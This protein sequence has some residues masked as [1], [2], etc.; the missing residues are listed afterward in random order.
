MI[1][2]LQIPDPPPWSAQ[3]AAKRQVPCPRNRPTEANQG[4]KNG[5][6]RTM[7]LHF[8][9][10]IPTTLLPVFFVVLDAN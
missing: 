9:Q 1:I 6:G 8:R 4:L 3:M 5:V 7:L 2:D 10:T